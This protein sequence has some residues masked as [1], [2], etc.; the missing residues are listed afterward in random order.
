M[1]KIIFKVYLLLLGVL[2][3]ILSLTG[4][5]IYDL[6]KKTYTSYVSQFVFA[7]ILLVFI[8]Y[9]LRVL[10]T[11][12]DTIVNITEKKA[13]IAHYLV[14]KNVTLQK[15]N[16]TSNQKVTK[17]IPEKKHKIRPKLIQ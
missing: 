2:S 16:V 10:F 15:F 3:S 9:I 4:L 1:K 13:S 14:S 11:R 5:Q 12:Q 17:A 8:T 6:H 7:S